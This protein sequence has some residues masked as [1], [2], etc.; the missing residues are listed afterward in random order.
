MKSLK[1]LKGVTEQDIKTAEKKYKTAK[2]AYKEKGKAKGLGEKIG[3][4]AHK[5]YLKG[6]A[7]QHMVFAPVGGV[8]AGARSGK[9]AAEKEAAGEKESK[10]SRHSA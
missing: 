9:K 4:A 7:L 5:V 2:E 6:G 10:L 3:K 1:K 8:I